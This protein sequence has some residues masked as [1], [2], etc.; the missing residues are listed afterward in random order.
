MMRVQAQLRS[1]R[2]F[3]IRGYFGTFS[4]W[5]PEFGL[6]VVRFIRFIQPETPIPPEYEGWFSGLPAGN[7]RRTP[8]AKDGRPDPYTSIPGTSPITPPTPAIVIGPADPPGTNR[9]PLP[10][11]GD[12]PLPYVEPNAY[13]GAKP[14]F[15]S[16]GPNDP[17]A[18]QPRPLAKAI[19]E[20]DHLEVFLEALSRV[21]CQLEQSLRQQAKLIL[22]NP[23]V[24]GLL[25]LVVLV[26]ATVGGPIVS[27]ALA[28]AS[29]ADHFQNLWELK[30]FFSFVYEAKEKEDES[31]LDDAA[32]ALGNALTSVGLDNLDKLLAPL[33]LLKRLL[34]TL[35][36]GRGIIGSVVLIGSVGPELWNKYLK[37]YDKSQMQAIAEVVENNTAFKEAI[38]QLGKD[39]TWKAKLPNATDAIAA[40][41]PKAAEML[42]ELGDVIGHLPDKWLKRLSNLEP[43]DGVQLLQALERAVEIRK[44]TGMFSLKSHGQ[45]NLAYADFSFNLPNT[46][47]GRMMGDFNVYRAFSG[48]KKCSYH[49]QY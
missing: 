18:C 20:M 9:H 27:L 36:I 42:A 8:G 16:D 2:T 29:V 7:G 6:G 14:D 5:L 38:E 40:F 34:S 30:N 22:E 47:Q 24:L 13:D 11:G 39:D 21:P 37:R 10:T 19:S 31:K 15:L 43:S 23:Q 48:R 35:D 26:A 28:V 1:D 33:L 44:S 17:N 49:Y 41:G 45:S 25:A 32:V 46:T 4:H 12:T 3:A